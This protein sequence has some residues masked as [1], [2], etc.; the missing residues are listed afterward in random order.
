VRAPSITILIL[1]V[2]CLARVAHADQFFASNVTS[3]T[4]GTPNQPAFFDMSLA[5]GGP[6]GAGLSTQSLHVLTLGAGGQL[7]LD[8]G[9]AGAVLR[10]IVNDAGPDFIV[11]ENAFYAGGNSN[12]SMAELVY[13]EVSSDG[14]NF[15]RFSV[16]SNTAA[17]VSA[18]GTIDP[19]NVSGFAGLHPVF[20]NVATN[21]IDPFD[22][23]AAGG[24]AFDLA[25]LATDPLVIS[26]SVN[27]GAIR[28]VRTVDVIGDGSQ[29]D[30]N[31]HV[32][33]DAFGEGNGGADIDAVAVIH[34]V[35]EPGLLCLIAFSPC[36]VA[37]RKNR[38]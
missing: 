7:M 29:L 14:S 5:L 33:F 13:V 22:P 38:R 32:I 28:Y 30:K 1:G 15:A 18:F 21:A 3:W 4:V 37:G 10:T 27:L 25:D 17:P 12:A 26:G 31:G 23:N 6:R 9:S 11:F 35:P 24:D 8:F 19:A 34:G 20:A 16:V 36:L 2:T